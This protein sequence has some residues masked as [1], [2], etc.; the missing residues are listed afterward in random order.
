MAYYPK[1]NSGRS[2]RTVTDA[3]RG[4]NH[5]LKIGDGEFY[6]TE[7]LTAEHYPMLANR[8]KRGRLS[9]VFTKLQAIIAKDALYWEDNGTFYSNGIATGLTGLQITKPTQLVSMGAYVC[10]F[11]DK[12]YINTAKLTE[13]GDMGASWSYSGS[14]TYTM[15]HQDGTYYTDVT[16]SANMPTNPANGAIWIDTA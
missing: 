12:K 4:Y 13:Y 9:T 7:N 3:F 1:L 6:E 15:C 14:V 2:T 11:P 5:N 16:K 10:I 8:R